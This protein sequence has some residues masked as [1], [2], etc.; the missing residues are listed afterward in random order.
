MEQERSAAAER[1][2]LEE[3]QAEMEEQAKVDRE[4]WQGAETLLVFRKTKCEFMAKIT[5]VAWYKSL[6]QYCT[7]LPILD[8]Y[9]FLF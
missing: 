3:L 1:K 6:Y 2:R 8:E 4:R 9:E 7:I 5:D